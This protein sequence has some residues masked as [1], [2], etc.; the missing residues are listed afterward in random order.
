MKKL[1][2]MALVATLGLSACGVKGGLYFPEQSA[3]QEQK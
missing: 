3:Q 2:L 1:L